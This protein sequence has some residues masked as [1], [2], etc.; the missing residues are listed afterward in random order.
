MRILENYRINRLLSK[1]ADRMLLVAVLRNR[2]TVVDRWG[3]F[4]PLGLSMSLLWSVTCSSEQRKP[5]KGHRD[6]HEGTREGWLVECDALPA[7]RGPLPLRLAGVL[8][9]AALESA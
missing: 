7:L 6:I 9:G 8:F 1:A 3:I 5:E 2:F 4:Y